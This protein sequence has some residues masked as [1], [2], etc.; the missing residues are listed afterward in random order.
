LQ[1]RVKAEDLSINAVDYRKR[2]ELFTQRIAAFINYTENTKICRSV[3]TGNYFG[4]ANM[5][6]C[7]ICDNC[8]QLKK[9]KLTADDFAQIK[10]RIE[11][12]LSVGPVTI[13]HLLLKLKN[14][15]KEKAWEVIEFLQAERKIEVNK[16]GMVEQS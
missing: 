8:L 12:A 4:D 1:P 5:Q 3:I 14:I 6:P 2:K 10:Q 16:D 9:T 11:E 15:S 13:E 7:G